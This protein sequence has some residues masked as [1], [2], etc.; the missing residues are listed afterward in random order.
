MVLFQSLGPNF[1]D[2][3]FFLVILLFLTFT[4]DLQPSKIK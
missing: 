3:L 4:M 1:V 2:T